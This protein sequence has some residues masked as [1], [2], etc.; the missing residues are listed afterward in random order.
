[1]IDAKKLSL[2]IREKKRKMKE[3]E[4][5]VKHM[6]L[7]D[8]MDT[9]DNARLQDTVGFKDDGEKPEEMT[10]EEDTMLG[11]D[12]AKAARKARLM[13]HLSSMM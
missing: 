7:S 1:M 5:E 3:P 9:L 10:A 12:K 11:P 2:L 6:N 4:E 13:S 8:A